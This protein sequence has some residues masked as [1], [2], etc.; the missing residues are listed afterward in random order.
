LTVAVLELRTQRL[1]LRGWRDA[2][3][4]EI[5]R[6]CSDPETMRYM[7]PSRPLTRAEA[8][9]DVENLREHWRV[10]GFGNWAVEELESGRLIGRAGVKRHSDWPLDPLNTEVGWL[11]DRAVWGRGLAS[12]GARAAVNFCFEALGRPEVISITHPDNAASRRVMEKAGLS[13][14]GERRWEEKGLDVVW[15][16]ARA[17]YRG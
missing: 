1:L 6:I 3:V 2:D 11:L 5:A 7:L 16:S 17:P 13:F 8:A 12:E 4:D 15:Y 10:H 9:L 14:A